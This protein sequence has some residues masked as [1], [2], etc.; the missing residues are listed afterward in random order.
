MPL[1]KIDMSNN[2]IPSI[3]DEI[4]SQEE[5]GWLNMSNNKLQA[6]PNTLFSLKMIK[7]LDVSYNQ[8]S[9]ISEA[10]GGAHS[11]VELRIAGN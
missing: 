10:L 8:I 6:L 9:V 1:T 7:F 4:G 3:P 11:L 5:I 2:E